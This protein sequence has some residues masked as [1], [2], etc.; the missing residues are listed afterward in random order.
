MRN[1]VILTVL[2]LF[3]VA[4]MANGFTQN[5]RKYFKVGEDFVKTGKYQ[6]A[7]TQFSKAIEMD[8]DFSKAYLS[9]GKVYEQINQPEEALNDYNRA[10]V[11]L[12]KDADTYYCTG[13]IYN[14]LG[15]YKEA[16]DA[17][18]K[19]TR[20]ARR[21]V[22]AYQEKAKA[23]ISLEKYKKAIGAADTALLL[24]KDAVG[25][26]L[27]GTANE[28]LGNFSLAEQDYNKSANADHR[29]IDPHLSQ[30][31]MALDLDRTD[32]AMKEC[33]KALQIDDK[34]I[35]AYLLRSKVYVKQLDYPNAINDISRI[36]LVEPDNA[37]MFFLRGTYYQKFN[38]HP[39]AIADFTKVISLQ[40]DKPEAYFQR[41]R[42]YEEILD[43]KHAVKDYQTLARRFEDNIKAEKLLKAAQERLYELNR[44][45]DPPVVALAVPKPVGKNTIEI[46]GNMAEVI[47]KGTI[48]DQSDLASVKINGKEIHTEK[49]D[50]GYEFLANAN[51]SDT[52]RLVIAAS[53]IYNNETKMEYAI[54][55]TE[56]NPPQVELLAPYASDNG[57]VYLESTEPMLYIEG[58][59]KDESLIKDIKIEGVLASYRPDDNNPRFSATI[60]IKNKKSFQVTVED[61][62]GNQTNKVFTL[63]REAAALG[64][65]NPMGKTWAIFIENS[66]YQ[67]FASLDGPPK[68]ISLMKKALANYQ[69][70]NV[71]VKQD[72][73]KEQLDK[74]FSIELRDLVR[75]NHVNSLLIWYAGHGKFI[76]ETGYWIPVDA[77]RD[78]EFTYY[79]INNLKAAL[80]TYSN[81]V[82]HTLVVTDACE[83]GP[84]FYQ[85]MRSIPEERSCDDWQATKFKSSQVFSS[86]GYEL[87]VD[88]SQFTRTFANTLANNPNAC[89]PIESIVKK[90]T[91]AVVKNN[92]QRPQFGKIAGLED[93]NGTFFFISR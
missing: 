11:F 71:I 3:L 47:L 73:T 25:Y 80:Q 27:H 92:Q 17:L 45:S 68:D 69:I 76:N 49:T 78:D 24:Q 56:I 16:L 23:L 58:Q 57:E 75:S 82:T 61:I 14:Q 54:R 67:T 51:L 88:N 62:Y 55:R 26:Y 4:G 50:D 65:D 1:K 42:S 86:A 5:A 31:K 89:L 12:P 38:Q 32:L 9:R 34:N 60:D 2:T 46:P 52:D 19:A 70:S 28:H 48:T 90:V 72:M 22:E 63:N 29:F 10:L 87:A 35:K 59:I 7:L 36:L 44:E 64:Q 53:D 84:T 77:A 20:L 93:E 39:Y 43:M 8:P 33:N 21:N 81:W 37:D 41:A 66:N 6:D 30:A 74:F 79:N 15:K 85:A 18:N 83:S 40:P 91:V 13:R